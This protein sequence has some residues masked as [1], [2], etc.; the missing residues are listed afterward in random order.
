MGLG[1]CTSS[2]WRRRAPALTAPPVA[3]DQT[4]TSAWPAADV[5]PRPEA[6]QFQKVATQRGGCTK[7]ATKVHR[8][9]ALPLQDRLPSAGRAAP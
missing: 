1:D 8:M 4:A 3:P 5:A 7:V 9:R 2:A 6:E